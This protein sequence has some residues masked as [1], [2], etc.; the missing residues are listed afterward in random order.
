VDDK[1]KEKITKEAQ[2]ILNWAIMHLKGN[3]KCK[4]IGYKY[5]NYT[6]Q[7]FNKENQLIMPVQIP[8]QWIKSSKPTENF[9]HDQLEMLLKNLENY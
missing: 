2:E 1:D 9:I 3:I 6:V 8:V 7:V 4:V 5:E